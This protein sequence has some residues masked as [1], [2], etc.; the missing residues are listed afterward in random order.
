M[1]CALDIGE[2]WL[3]PPWCWLSVFAGLP[4]T[5]RF[6]LSRSLSLTL[7]LSPC[8]PVSFSLSLSLR[9][10][11]SLSI[12]IGYIII[13]FER[14]TNDSFVLEALIFTGDLVANFATSPG[15]V[16]DA[17]PVVF[18]STTTQNVLKL[19]ATGGAGVAAAVVAGVAAVVVAA[20]AI[21]AFLTAFRWSK[22]SDQ[23][24]L[25]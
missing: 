15:Q 6:S 10:S 14:R 24:Q 12:I 2:I 20:T 17:S 21:V 23:C 11:L 4:F 9:F 19:A 25:W 13:T 7:S 8:F 3:Y 22:L 16:D 1:K 5:A 18:F